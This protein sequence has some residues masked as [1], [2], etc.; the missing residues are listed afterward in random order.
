MQELYGRVGE[1]QGR[2]EQEAALQQALQDDDDESTISPR[3]S[4]STFSRSQ[5]NDD[6]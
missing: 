1:M 4:T 3:S 5:D 6:V 2:P